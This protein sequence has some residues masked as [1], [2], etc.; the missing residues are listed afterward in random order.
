MAEFDKMKVILNH[1]LIFDKLYIV[2]KTMYI[3]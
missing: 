3:L 2:F 1:Q